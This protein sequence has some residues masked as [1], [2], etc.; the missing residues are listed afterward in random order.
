LK[1]FD[2]LRLFYICHLSKPA[3]NRP[4]YQIVRRLQALK[5]VE[6]GIADCHDAVRMI[7]VARLASPGRQVEYIGFDPFE[8]RNAAS[9]MTLK[10]AYQLL[11]ATGARVRL[12]PGNPAETLPQAAN[13]L[14]KIDLLI[15][16]REL[17]TEANSRFWYFVPRMLHER[18]VVFLRNI[19]AEG[20]RFDI[21]PGEEIARLASLGASR[22]AA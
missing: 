17:A 14:G 1:V 16:P 20:R 8:G 19:E 10:A 22:R 3:N 18:T 2:K 21:L 13:S 11:R 4:V 6:L 12:M 9:V 15:L 7:L 5:I